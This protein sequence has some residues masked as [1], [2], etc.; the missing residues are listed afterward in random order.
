MARGAFCICAAGVGYTQVGLVKRPA[1][2]EWVSGHIPGTAAYWSGPLLHPAVCIHTADPVSAGV[3]ALPCRTCRSRPWTVVMAFAFIAAGAVRVTE[4]T[5]GAGAEGPVIGRLTACIRCT[6]PRSA[7]LGALEVAALGTGWAVVVRVTLVPA[8]LKWLSHVAWETAAGR[9]AIHHF[10]SCVPST[11]AGVAKLLWVERTTGREWVPCVPRWTGAYRDV[12]P[13]SA[14]CILAALTF[15]DVQA[16]VVSANP[17]P[18]TVPALSA[19][20]PLTVGE[21]V[22][23]IAWEANTDRPA[24]PGEALGVGPAG[25]GVTRVLSIG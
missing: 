21:G 8:S 9:H 13:R 16:A 11:G 10:A 2:D 25:A 14:L 17:A 22:S 6:R 1:R 15:A 3:Y 12:V 18:R 5:R 7:D 24:V 4:C 23:P 20:A 19:L